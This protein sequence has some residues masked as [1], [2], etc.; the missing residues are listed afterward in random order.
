MY[1]YMF[2]CV[3]VCHNLSKLTQ[4]DILGNSI[5]KSKFHTEIHYE[6]I[7]VTECLIWFS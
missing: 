2:I 6:N 4:F 1:I 5:T 7:S 3:C